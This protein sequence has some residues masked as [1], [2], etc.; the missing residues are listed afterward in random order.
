MIHPLEIYREAGRRAAL[1]FYQHDLTK[2][3][4]E[5]TWLTLTARRE[6]PLNRRAARE[7]F[8]QAF[9]EAD[10]DTKRRNGG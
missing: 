3:Q 10:P 8:R 9:R 6:L 5:F 2:A 1:A 7:A 4:A